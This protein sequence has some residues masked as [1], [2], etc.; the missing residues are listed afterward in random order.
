MTTQSAT[1]GTPLPGGLNW[2]W[3][4]PR[5]TDRRVVELA[6]APVRCM[7]QLRQVDRFTSTTTNGFAVRGR[8]ELAERLL[9]QL[10][11]L[12]VHPLLAE[13]DSVR[14]VRFTVPASLSRLPITTARD[15]TSGQSLVH[16]VEP[17][18]QWSVHKRDPERTTGKPQVVRLDGHF[19]DIAARVARMRL[20]RGTTLLLF[21]CRTAE[22]LPLVAAAGADAA[23]V[24][25]W[26]VE[27]RHCSQFGQ[28]VVDRLDAGLSTAAAVRS[29][30][31]LWSHRHPYEWAGYSAVEFV[32]G[33]VRR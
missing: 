28:E 5:R 12:L 22:L 29:V 10:W 25:S 20:E 30:Q 13:V 8:Y 11:T 24:T 18:V 23:V 17:V 3:E 16:C 14:E 21:G 4:L 1:L 7:H 33:G 32:A 19:R 26:D 2:Q 15:A 31:A 6:G 9:D 27:D